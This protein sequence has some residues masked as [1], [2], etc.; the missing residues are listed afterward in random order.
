MERRRSQNI[1][2]RLEKVNFESNGKRILKDISMMIENN[3]TYLLVGRNG[4]GKS[5][6]LKLLAGIIE[7]SSG[8]LYIDGKEVKDS[9]ELRE[10]V[11]IVFQNPQTQIIGSTVEEDAAFGLENLGIEPDVIEK[12][13]NEVL[14][15]VGLQDYRYK[16]PLELSG[17]FMQRLAIASI[18]VLD[19]KVLLLDEPLSMLDKESKKDVVNLLKSFH[20]EKTMIVATHEFD[21]FKFADYVIYM[22]NGNASVYDF[23]SFF[24]DPPKNFIIPAWIK[25]F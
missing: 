21:Y 25:P 13:V 24:K 20:G 1:Q 2:I 9:W 8:R 22:D 6:L 17:G 12:K 7:P 11:G 15:I 4:S 10:I 3:M 19:P 5:T 18:L 16:D 14:E 23:K